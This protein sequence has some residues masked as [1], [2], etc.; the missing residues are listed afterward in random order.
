MVCAIALFWHFYCFFG[1]RTELY[2]RGFKPVLSG[3]ETGRLHFSIVLYNSTF[4][5]KRISRSVSSAFLLSASGEQGRVSGEFHS[6]QCL[7][8]YFHL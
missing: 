4:L 3:C 5:S 6:S 7:W 2:V 8:Y 1:N